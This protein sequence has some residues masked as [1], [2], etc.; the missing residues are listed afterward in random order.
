MFLHHRQNC[1]APQFEQGKRHHSHIFLKQ[2]NTMEYLQHEIEEEEESEHD[3]DVLKTMKTAAAN[4]L[5]GN[6]TASGTE[7]ASTALDAIQE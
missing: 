4:Y 7:L 6:A 3:P 2:D 1:K 5:K